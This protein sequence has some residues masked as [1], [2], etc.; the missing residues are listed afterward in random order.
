MGWIV[1]I[2]MYA[3]FAFAGFRRAKSTNQW[4][5]S[6]FFFALAFAGVEVLIITLPIFSMN[7]DGRYFI[8]VYATAWVIALLNFIWFIMVC[9]RWRLP[10][11]RTSLE[12]AREEK[13]ALKAQQSTR[14][15]LPD[16]DH[17]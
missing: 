15:Q 14:S 3:Y 8:A 9:R 16:L 13:A 7:T 5:W 1:F 6:L 4:S 12:A 10:D 17:K 11:G 2:L